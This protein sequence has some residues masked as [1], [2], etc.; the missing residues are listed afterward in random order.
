MP[1]GIGYG[2]NSRESKRQAFVKE[3]IAQ[4]AK[5]PVKKKPESR[6]KKLKRTIKELIGGSKT[7][8]PKKDN[9]TT[10]RTKAVSDALSR[11]GVSSSKIARLRRK[12]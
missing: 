10:V 4:T 5:A 6:G 2:K 11:A 1:K 9:K 7:Y 8:L 12:K 3:M